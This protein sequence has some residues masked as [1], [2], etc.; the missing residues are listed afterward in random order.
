MIFPVR[1]CV[2]TGGIHP[3][4]EYNEGPTVQSN[5]T[6]PI[7][8]ISTVLSFCLAMSSENNFSSWSDIV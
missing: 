7:P 8:I 1:Q 4:N 6:S 3:R 5:A 2:S